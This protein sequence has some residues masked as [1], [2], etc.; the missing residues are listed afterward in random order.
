MA[1]TRVWLGVDG[2][3]GQYE[4]SKNG[5]TINTS[6]CHYWIGAD[7]L[8]PFKKAYQNCAKSSVKKK[9]IRYVEEE[10]RGQ[11]FCRG[12]TVKEAV[13]GQRKRET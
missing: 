6:L 4:S 1:F 7:H 10:G 12:G 2:H 11:D 5:A 3:G 8:D 9:D 13:Q